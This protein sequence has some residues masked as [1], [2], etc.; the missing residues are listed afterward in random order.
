MFLRIKNSIWYTKCNSVINSVQKH[1][2]ATK[3]NSTTL[4]NITGHYSCRQKHHPPHWPKPP[5]AGR[6][7]CQLHRW[8]S[9]LEERS[10][11]VRCSHCNVH[12]CISCFEKF[13]V[14]K[15]L[16]EER[17]IIGQHQRDTFRKNSNTT[18]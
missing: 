6:P 16:I 2:R 8:A 18:P 17:D 11:V 9:N 4:N 12:L 14:T 1:E 13:H 3:F 7:R 5:I 15:D 10:D